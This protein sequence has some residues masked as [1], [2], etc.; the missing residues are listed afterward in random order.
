MLKYKEKMKL[1]DY[2]IESRFMRLTTFD[3]YDFAFMPEGYKPEASWRYDNSLRRHNIVM[4][5]DVD[6][7]A[8]KELWSRGK[9]TFVQ[10]IYDHE[11]AHSLFTDRDHLRMSKLQDAA[12]IPFHLW[13]LM[14]DAR[15]EA[16]WRKAFRRRFGWLRFLNLID[17]GK[18]HPILALMKASGQPDPAVRLFLDCTRMENSPK[19]ME[20]WVKRDKEPKIKFE[21][22][23]D[24]KYGRRS[25]IRWYYRRSIYAASTEDIIPIVQ[26]WLKTFPESGGG[27]EE[28][29]GGL[30]PGKGF[31]GPHGTDR[32]DPKG[33]MKPAA[34][35]MPE[36]AQ[37]ADGSE[38]EEIE[39]TVA[40]SSGASES[41]DKYK[42]DAPPPAF[43]PKERHEDMKFEI[44]HNHFFQRS[45]LRTIDFAKADRLIRLFEKFL[46]G[47][48]GVVTSRNPTNKID[49]NKLMRGADDIYL[50]KGDDPYGVKKMSFILDCSG[51]MSGVIHQGCYL[52]YVLNELKK[53]RR[54]ECDNMIL[55][56]GDYYKVPMP[57]NPKLLEHIYTPGGIEGFVPTMKANTAELVASDLTIF[58][59]DGIITDQ[60]IKKEEWHRKGVYTVG[61]YVGNPGMSETL[62]QWFD[63]VLVR[64]DIESIADS[65]VQIIKRQ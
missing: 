7:C 15:I 34:G 27:G 8:D 61:L 11:G 46:E 52:A 51:S 57:F 9:V 33:A 41:S 58:F 2:H 38:H 64:E 47:G 21:G 55:S 20:A 35:V 3:G 49:F 60:H 53:R 59:T 25:L 65:L 28:G 29:A 54:I 39:E 62:H 32:P 26:S 31:A 63:S 12:K 40:T 30:A 43:D 4:A 24:P 13:N 36:G 42:K 44:P 48:E 6:T 45:K 17:E 56:G 18:P 23:G 37:D 22:T 16:R 5:A 50:R 10:R 19:M 14:E 1:V